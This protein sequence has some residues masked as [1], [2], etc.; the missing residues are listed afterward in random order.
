MKK[1]FRASFILLIAMIIVCLPLVQGLAADSKLYVLSPNPS[2]RLH[3]RKQPTSKSES[4]GKFYTGTMVEA[5]GDSGDYTKVRVFGTVGYMQT[6]YLSKAQQ[7]WSPGRWASVNLEGSG[8]S[9]ALLSN[10]SS[11][12]KALAYCKD[13]T[14]VQILGESGDYYQVR[15][16]AQDGYMPKKSLTEDG[17]AGRIVIRPLLWGSI[18]KDKVNLRCAPSKDALSLGLMNTG[19]FVSILGTVGVWYYVEI[20]QAEW[21]EQTQARIVQRGFV[22]GQYL[23]RLGYWGDSDLSNPETRTYAVIQNPNESDRLH[24]RSSPSSSS[25][26]L[27]RYLNNAQAEVLDSPASL[28]QAATLLT[29]LHVRIDGQEGYMQ[30]KYLVMISNGSSSDG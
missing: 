16:Y 23:Q 6:K 8:N 28:Y 15:T 5:L 18:G 29:W 25:A 20:G 27:G 26:S 4:L 14:A 7:E 13:G 21:N 3:L 10:A 12:G 30:R 2:D 22:L 17:K 19:D 1:Q 11:Q 9:Q 24:L